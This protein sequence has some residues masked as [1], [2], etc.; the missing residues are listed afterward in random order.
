MMKVKVK[1]AKDCIKC[2]EQIR[3]SLYSTGKEEVCSDCEIMTEIK[4]RD[5]AKNER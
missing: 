1:G 5:G 4:D 3:K 2:G